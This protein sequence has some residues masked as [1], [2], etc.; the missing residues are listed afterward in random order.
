MN[1][2]KKNVSFSPW[3]LLIAAA[4]FH[5]VVTTL[6]FSI[7]RHALMAGAFDTDGIAVSFAR[8]GSM[9]RQDATVLAGNLKRGEF[10]SW[11]TSQYP[12]HVKLY[13][14]SFLIFGSLLGF[15]ILALEPLNLL[16]YLGILALVYRLA[17]EPFGPRAGLIAA[18]AV[19]IWPTLLLHTTQPL[20]DPLFLVSMLTIIFIFARLIM[21]TRAWRE[22]LLYG[23]IGGLVAAMLWRARTEMAPVLV[24]TV[25]IGAA[26]FGIRQFQLGR[27]VG[28]NVAGMT[29]LV[30]L[31]AAVIFW[32]PGYHSPQDTADFVRYS[33]GPTITARGTVKGTFRA[34][35]WSV[36]AQ[37]SAKR[38]GFI[39][40]YSGS[41]SNIDTN[42]KFGNEWELIR[43][44]PRAIIIGLFAPF[45]DMWFT[46]GNSVGRIGRILSGIEMLL[47]YG[48]EILA[49]V[50]LWLRRRDLV[51]WLFFLITLM[52]AAAL[53]L[54][55]VNIGAL[56]RFRYI[57][58]ILLIILAA[59]GVTH[60]V[61]WLQQR[62]GWVRPIKTGL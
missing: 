40:V 52:G 18:A 54:V 1:D 8:D 59:G 27:A 37:V 9:Y 4:I 61:E 13:S 2:R 51:A 22:S 19:A 26:L 12:F 16:C 39:R 42:V 48:I 53:G 56:Y 11:F 24:G 21:R 43:Y 50:W 20:K 3:R 49:V 35:W 5:V 32:I 29:L 58:L 28:S 25:M 7:G 60:T 47:M 45:P 17:A 36:A 44:L 55:I 6:V 31:T 57:F 46:S 15:N 33:E 10:R 38:R 62:R 14:I 41:S 34:P 23:L 30:A